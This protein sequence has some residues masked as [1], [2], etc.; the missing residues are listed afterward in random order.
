MKKSDDA[1][2]NNWCRHQRDAKAGKNGKIFCDDA[3]IERL[4]ALGFNWVPMSQ[5]K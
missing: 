4:D 5:R 2:L 1:K 3:Q